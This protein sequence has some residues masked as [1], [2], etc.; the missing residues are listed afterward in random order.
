MTV[1]VFS[2]P[3]SFAYDAKALNITLDLLKEAIECI[4]K[5]KLVKMFNGKSNRGSAGCLS[6]AS[7][8]NWIAT[9][10]FVKENPDEEDKD[11]FTGNRTIIKNG[12]LWDDFVELIKRPISNDVVQTWSNLSRPKLGDEA[13][14]HGITLGIRNINAVKTLLE[15]M[16]KMFER[17]QR[18]F[19]NK[20]EEVEVS[21][22]HTVSTEP[23]LNYR[24]MNVPALHHLCKERKIV[25]NKMKKDDMLKALKTYDDEKTEIIEVEY[26]S[27][28]NDKL[29]ALCKERKLSNYNKLN[30]ENLIKKLTQYDENIK[31]VKTVVKNDAV[32]NEVTYDDISEDTYDDVSEDTYDDKNEGETNT[33][34]IYSEDKE[35][36]LNDTKI[37]ARASDGYISATQLC[38]AGGKKKMYDYLR[39]SQTKEFLSELS[40]ES[41][42]PDSDLVKVDRGGNDGTWI[43]R[44]VAYHL[45][46]WI[47]PKFAVKVSTW[48]DE[49][50]ITGNV[51]LYNE[52]SI[53]S[54]EAEYKSK[55]NVINELIKDTHIEETLSRT[56][57]DREAEQLELAFEWFKFTNDCVLYL[58]YIGNGL[59]KLGYSDCGLVER[60]KK[61]MSSAETE[62]DQF[63]LIAAFKISS[64]KI[65]T[66]MKN[67]LLRYKKKFNKQDEIYQPRCNLK[68]F[69]EM[70][71][72][73]LVDN[74]LKYQLD[75]T[76]AEL[77]SVK[78]ELKELRE[79]FTE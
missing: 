9:L 39:L 79:S 51:Q 33:V 73:L 52:K 28:T 25:S 60:E 72:T 49:L 20:V 22:I 34:Q 3:K 44:K 56:D 15:R 18:L 58:A 17:R 74:D 77:L 66:L 29:K 61:H 68:Q 70:V 19:W 7:L 48:L 6:A 5:Q 4:G 42:I 8:D 57:L 55:L 32:V 64:R 10:E 63:R 11:V 62:F 43:H 53:S 59:I 16:N 54:V 69:R 36:S 31:R 37:V 50:F 35:L 75:I 30:K 45:A 41:G 38:K 1:I 2:N 78:Q 23:K 65:E 67:L 40:L 27:M 76:K 13:E 71:Q 24:L 46:Q 26:E 21:E 12:T 14:K 47:S